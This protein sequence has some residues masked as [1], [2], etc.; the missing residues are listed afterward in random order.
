MKR[1]LAATAISVTMGEPVMAQEGV[2]G[3]AIPISASS[4]SLS[5]I[6]SVSPAL[7]RYA[8]EDV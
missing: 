2:G 1:L 3:G 6:Q 4:L 8:E 7:G 5:D